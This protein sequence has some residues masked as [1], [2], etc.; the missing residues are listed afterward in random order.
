MTTESRNDQNRAER[1]LRATLYSIGDAVIAAD[2]QARLTMMNPVAEKL[3]G[4][5]EREARGKALGTVFRIVNEE[6]RKKVENPV[7]RVLRE[8][9]V[10]GFANHTLLISR[11]G[12]EIPIAD[13]GAP[14][15]DSNGKVVGVVLVFRD[16]TAQRKAQ[17]AVQDAREF[18][19]SIVATVRE[20]LLILDEKLEVVSANRSFYNVFKVKP[21]E[22]IGEKIYHLGNRQWNIP[23]LRTLLEEILPSNSHFDDFEVTHDFEHIGRRTMVLNARRIFREENRSK[24]ILLA[25]EDITERKRAEE[26][27][28]KKDEHHKAVIESIFKFIPEGVLVLTESLNLLKQ[29]KAFEE[30]VQ[31]YAPLLGYTEQELTEKIIEQLRSKMLTADTTEIRIPIAKP[32]IRE[33]SE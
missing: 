16:Q 6:T 28:R 14:I 20:P 26:I 8:G 23:A 22:T 2:R 5:K 27:L 7:K 9:I 17:R 12:K 13:A 1:I 18:A 32:R 31:K 33:K 21:E 25:I 10:V 15:K 3:T 11:K 4:W 19:E 29:N 30:I 24:L